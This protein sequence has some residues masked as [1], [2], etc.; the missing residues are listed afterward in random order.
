MTLFGVDGSVFDPIAP[1]RV[2]PLIE[3]AYD[4]W[5]SYALI[6]RS[7]F[8]KIET[9]P[10]TSNERLSIP[11]GMSLVLPVIEIGLKIG[12]LRFKKIKAYIVDY[13]NY[14]FIIGS[15]IIE[16]I[17]R[18]EYMEKSN[19]SIASSEKDNSN[20]LSLRLHSTKENYYVL[21]F[22]HYLGTQRKLYNILLILNDEIS[23]KNNFEIEEIIINE[24]DIPD[25]KKLV[26]SWIEKGSIWIT[27]KSIAKSLSSLGKLL[28]ESKVSEL[29]KELYEAEKSKTESEIL[30]ETR[31]QIVKRKIE[32]EKKLTIENIHESQ[33]IWRQEVNDRIKFYEDLISKISDPEKAQILKIQLEKTIS[34]LLNQP[35]LPETTNIPHDK[36]MRGGNDS[37]L[38]IL[39]KE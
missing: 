20:Y 26:I 10:I 21:D 31:N 35:F 13:G 1:E 15:D 16:E 27:F 14:D 17:L 3:L 38:P 5:Y 32:E 34:E 30:S 23:I 6:K 24:K 8:E 25:E 18:T 36:L 4:D 7:L 37:F 22:E 33:K 39:Y 29:K 28:G 2:F 9:I 19:L 11:G 12:F